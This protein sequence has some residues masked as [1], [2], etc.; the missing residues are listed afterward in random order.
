MNLTVSNN[1]S[2]QTSPPAVESSFTTTAGGGARMSKAKNERFNEFG[3][4]LRNQRG[5]K[6]QD[7]IGKLSKFS[8]P[9]IS[10]LESGFL[11][12]RKYAENLKKLTQE[13]QSK[14]DQKVKPAGKGKKTDANVN[15]SELSFDEALDQI[16]V[17][18]ESEFIEGLLNIQEGWEN[19]SNIFD[20]EQRIPHVLL[21]LPEQTL[22]S[23][24][25]AYETTVA[26]LR[27]KIE[28][29]NRLAHEA[30][31]SECRALIGG[32]SEFIEID[33]TLARIGPIENAES[34]AST[35]SPKGEKEGEQEFLLRRGFDDDREKLMKLTMRDLLYIKGALNNPTSLR[36]ILSSLG[37]A[38]YSNSIAKAKGD[39]EQAL[40]E[41]GMKLLN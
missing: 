21:D 13:I 12:N 17:S 10:Q 38:N 20:L 39:V 34:P 37:M 2:L 6:S 5:K 32:V 30:L 35:L 40:H 4:F 8:T 23:L 9:Y 3:N 1:E 29:G 19:E 41:I 7:D 22:R 36:T 16:Q 26:V 25:Y 15:L 18:G 33:E 28:I 11:I 14:R 24:A 31:L 27:E